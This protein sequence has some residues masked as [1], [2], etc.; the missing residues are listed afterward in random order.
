MRRNHQLEAKQRRQQKIEE[1]LPAGAAAGLNARIVNDEIKDWQ[2]SRADP[3][4][5]RLWRSM[6][7]YFN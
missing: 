2:G 1:G 3:D 6:R 4:S 5:V 7:P